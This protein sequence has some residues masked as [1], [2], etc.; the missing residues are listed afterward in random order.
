MLVDEGDLADQNDGLSVGDGGR[1]S[2]LSL[3]ELNL[4]SLGSTFFSL[5]PSANEGLS[6][7]YGLWT[8]PSTEFGRKF[9]SVVGVGAVGRFEVKGMRKGGMMGG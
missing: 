5:M 8:L 2:P 1:Y 9:S 4:N 7:P 3:T 6:L